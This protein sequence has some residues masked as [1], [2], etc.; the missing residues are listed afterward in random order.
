[1]QP[2]GGRAGEE[3]S[4]MGTSR[5]RVPTWY[6]PVWE[7]REENIGVVAGGVLALVGEVGK[8]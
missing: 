1:M 8:R 4:E 6:F 3:S 7:G 2:R 5:S